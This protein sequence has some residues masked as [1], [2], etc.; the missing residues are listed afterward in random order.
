[1]SNTILGYI[2]IESESMTVE[3][4]SEKRAA[5]IREIIQ[6]VMGDKAHYKTTSIKPMRAARERAEDDED[7]LGF[8]NKMMQDP[9]VREHME[10]MFLDHWGQWVD[11]A[12]PILD[13]QTPREAAKSPSGREK[14]DALIQSACLNAG[15]N[16]DMDVQKKGIELARR[17]LGF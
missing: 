8:H 14:V 11:T 15:Q 7:P 9:A 1:M 3:V 12:L 10:N 5:E 13:G 17:D 6:N 2:D 4:N 16:P